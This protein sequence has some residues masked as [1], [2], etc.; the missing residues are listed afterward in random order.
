[1]QSRLTVPRLP[2]TI[3][4]AHLADSL[5][6]FVGAG[7]SRGHPA[8][9]PSFW[10]LAE[11]IAEGTGEKVKEPLD[12]FLGHLKRQGPNVHS[13][14]K[15]I[16][17][18][19]VD[20]TPVHKDILRLFGVAH[21]VRIVT[22]NF[23]RIL[24]EAAN[25]FQLEHPERT[26]NHYFGPALPYG[27][28]FSG[29]VHLHGSIDQPA[30]RL[31]LTDRDFS[32]AYIT[33]GWARDFLID[34]FSNYTVLFVGY[35]H[36]DTIIR[37]L[38]RGIPAEDSAPRFALEKR[39]G[40]YFR[41]PC[42]PGEERHATNANDPASSDGKESRTSETRDGSERSLREKDAASRT[43]WEFLGVK[44]VFFPHADG[45]DSYAHLHDTLEVWSR[46]LRQSGA[47]HAQIVQ[48]IVQS[49]EHAEEKE[50]DGEQIT[51]FF[52]SP[53]DGDKY[54]LKTALRTTAG[55]RA[56]AENAKSIGW[57]SWLEDEGI[58]AYQDRQ[59]ELSE[60]QQ[61]L[62]R[63]VVGELPHYASE[64]LLLHLTRKSARTQKILAPQILET[65]AFDTLPTNDAHRTR[66]LTWLLQYVSDD[67]QNGL[68]QLLECTAARKAWDDT[69]LLLDSL[70]EPRGL[71]EP[72]PFSRGEIHSTVSI[73]LRG[74]VQT[75]YPIWMA[76]LQPNLEQIARPLTFIIGNHLATLRR[77]A[78]GA[79]LAWGDH[80]DIYSNFDRHISDLRQARR[81]DA[82][83]GFL[84]KIAVEVL[85]WYTKHD[86]DA[87]RHLIERWSDSGAP[88]LVRLAIY[89][90]ERMESV[91]ADEKLQWLLDRGWVLEGGLIQESDRTIESAF[92]DASDPT[93]ERLLDAISDKIP[94]PD[95]EPGQGWSV[96][97]LLKALA[98]GS[99]DYEPLQALWNQFR[100][101][102]PNLNFDEEES[103][104]PYIASRGWPDVDPLTDSPSE[105]IDEII[106]AYESDESH[107]EAAQL[108][109]RV[110]ATIRQDKEWARGLAEDL[111]ARKKWDFYI[112]TP[113]IQAVAPHS[114]DGVE[115]FY[116]FV[117]KHPTLIA[118]GT[119]ITHTMW[120]LSRPNMEWQPLFSQ[121]QRTETLVGRLL[122]ELENYRARDGE[123]VDEQVF[124]DLIRVYWNLWWNDQ[125]GAEPDEGII[126][127]HARRFEQLL[128][129]GP[130]IGYAAVRVLVQEVDGIH[131]LD[132]I[133]ARGHLLPL[134]EWDDPKRA[135]IAW[136][137][138]LETRRTSAALLGEMKH[139][140]QFAFP[141]L[142]N[143]LTAHQ[144][145]FIEKMADAAVFAFDP[146]SD[147]W[148][149]HF[150]SQADNT[151]R[152]QWTKEV[153]VR[154]TRM[155]AEAVRHIWSEWLGEYWERRLKEVKPVRL[156]NEELHELVKTLP[157]LNGVFQDAV[158]LLVRTDPISIAH[159]SGALIRIE[160]KGLA[161]DFPG[162][163]LKLLDYLIL[164]WENR[165]VALG[166]RSKRLLNEVEIR[167]QDRDLFRKIVEALLDRGAINPDEAKSLLSLPK[168]D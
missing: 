131:Y 98:D 116:G 149:V 56:F 125:P 58:V 140:F 92:S 104:D 13:S 53:I 3:R 41:S 136:S 85:E 31:V 123:A 79:G 21:K 106:D 69:L 145:Q 77:I 59:A 128:S 57:L 19:N 124:D 168:N 156:D 135:R 75:I 55:A 29:I 129:Q 105:I 78:S 9:L 97:R 10:E 83:I 146:T 160:K 166:R 80:W 88:L 49:V 94:P 54:N 52:Q 157:W 47:D 2:E 132:P 46:Q 15:D 60:A 22:T 70:T 39:A 107:G 18:V 113:L 143:E 117:E 120:S 122:D 14:A 152:V 111:A 163:T 7:V 38:A 62:H 126:E 137:A 20:P 26:I 96:G 90:L 82:P 63:W 86:E 42:I 73:Q 40:A 45:S 24:T 30:K 121:Q 103:S 28:D 89:G 34:L 35:S 68:G 130:P 108:R 76:H 74:D 48:D 36:E 99:P 93:R 95:A 142:R 91:A 141:H 71:V 115:W 5:V 162:A 84:L 37:Y 165:A 27:D 161:S 147:D 100:C 102:H 17:S 25:I 139:L 81:P 51:T 144:E 65:F 109:R 64:A 8:C 67:R 44:P 167:G 133:W 4:Q 32:K 50:S 118:T 127:K 138:F 159:R 153:R 114:E 150:L 110:E 66:W 23:D 1:M 43:K 158:D 154:L 164:G 101:V 61:F 151:L 16:F 148:I 134:L 72:N 155:D 112:W 11:Q 12:Q 119:A 33:R 6:V 87:T